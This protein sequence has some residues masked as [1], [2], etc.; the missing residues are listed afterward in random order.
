MARLQVLKDDE[1][2]RPYSDSIE[3]R[4]ESYLR[5]KRQIQTSEGS[6]EKFA[7]GY[8]VFGFQRVA[9]ERKWTYT[10]WLPEANQAFLV[11]DFN[12]WSNSHPLRNVGF[13]RW[14]CDLPDRRDG[15]SLLEHKSQV[16]VKLTSSSSDSFCSRVPAWT[17]MAVQDPQSFLFNGVFWNPPSGERYTFRHPRP[18]RPTSLK[19]YEA[20]VGM[21]STEPKVASYLEFKDVVLPRIKRLGYTAVQ[22]MA[23]AEHS[24]YGSF[25]Y[26]VTSFFAPASRSGTPEELREMIDA[27]HSMGIVVLMDLVHAHASS[28]QMDGIGAMDGTDYC[29]THGGGKG[30]HDQWDSSLFHYEKWE[31]MRF[32][33]S[34]CRWWIEEFGFDGFRFDGVTSMLYL[35]HGIDRGFSGDLGEYFGLDSDEE[36]SV[37]LMLAN[38][39]IHKLCPSAICV[40]EDVSGMPTLCRPVA[41]GG[42]GFDYRLSMAIPDMWIK[43]TKDTPDDDWNVGHIVH[44]LQNRRYKEGCIA[45]AESHDQSIV[46]DKSVAFRL[47]DAEMYT[48]MSCLG[49]DSMCID[50]GIALHKM[51]RLITLGLG[52]EGYL[53]FIGNEFGHPEWVDFPREGNDWSY[54][55]CRRRWDLA[56]DNNLKYKFMGAFEELMQHC[57]GRFSWLASD[58]QFASRQD[59]GDKVIA[60][61]RGPCLFV[62]NFHPTESFKD[63]RIGHPWKEGLRTV[64]D[65][66]EHRFGGYDRLEYGHNNSFPPLSGW[67]GRDHSTM[68]Y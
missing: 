62:F 66:D 28:N 24:Y 56:D 50:R 59:E 61:E 57:E 7:E 47:M 17:P 32:L 67:D 43:F 46:G 35:S 9:A 8:R 29:Y 36:A 58:H 48:H 63:Y 64:I 60:F 37:Y 65:T 2:L 31:V 20:H 12:G 30:H 33:L 52:G 1:W 6:L 11:G 25:G 23:V 5:L 16:R 34:N 53:N 15:S 41:E 44:T 42:F 49:P 4:F 18:P 19:I 39:L 51:I 3:G 14:Q 21:A 22:L 26:H 54:Q 13:G 38:D 55:H 68:L 27:A 45:Y 10:E 40:A